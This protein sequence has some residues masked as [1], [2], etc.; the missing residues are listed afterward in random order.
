[1]IVFTTKPEVEDKIVN[2]D[3][4]IRQ[5]RWCL[6]TSCSKTRG[7]Y[8]DLCREIKWKNFDWHP[9]SD[10]FSI[11]ITDHFHL[12]SS[13]LYYDGPHCSFSLGYLHFNWSYWWCKKCSP[14]D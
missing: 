14:D 7:Y 6:S 5:W 1:M 3:M 11:N 8:I 9:A 10:Y 13:H 4:G 2:S 12:G